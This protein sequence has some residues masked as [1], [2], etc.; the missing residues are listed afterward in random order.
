M[1]NLISGNVPDKIQPSDLLGREERSRS[2][3]KKSLSRRKYKVR[4]HAPPDRFMPPESSSELSINRM[5][6]APDAKMAAIGERNAYSDNRKEFWGWHT[7]SAQDIKDAGCS[8]EPSPT[9]ENPYHAD[10]IIPVPPDLEKE[11]RHDELIKYARLLSDRT[12]FHPWGDWTDK[13]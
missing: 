8:V 11:K 1:P 6:F 9:P 7:L 13:I 2:R 3:A 10:I 12:K 4:G 5:G